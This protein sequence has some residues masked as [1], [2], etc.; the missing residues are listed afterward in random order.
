MTKVAGAG[1]GLKTGSPVAESAALP[2]SDVVFF[3]EILQKREN[4]PPSKLYIDQEVVE[5]V[6]AFYMGGT[7]DGENGWYK[8][9]FYA[10]GMPRAAWWSASED[11]PIVGCW[12]DPIEVGQN[13][14]HETIEEINNIGL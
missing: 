11:N 2:L 8:I 9:A 3:G 7:K 6:I 14:D 13:P 10:D 5:E 12:P 4:S 1:Y